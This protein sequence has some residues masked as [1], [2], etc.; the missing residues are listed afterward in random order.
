VLLLV[1]DYPRDLLEL[2]TRFSIEAPNHWSN[3]PQTLVSETTTYW[4]HLR[5]VN[6]HLM[7]F[8]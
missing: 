4:G 3:D 1:E 5:D 2:E 7:R 6:T 8:Y